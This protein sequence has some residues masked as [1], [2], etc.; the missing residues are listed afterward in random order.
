M[1]RSR[2]GA[3]QAGVRLLLALAALAAGQSVAARA[4]STAPRAVAVRLVSSA[5]EAQPAHA[6]APLLASRPALAARPQRTPAIAPTAH[7][8]SDGPLYL[9]NRAILR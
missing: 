7:R 5:V 3:F 1:K 2:R 8:G 4:E 6:A 9:L